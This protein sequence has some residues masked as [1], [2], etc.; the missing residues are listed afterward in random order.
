MLIKEPAFCF[1]HLKFSLQMFK[2]KPLPVELKSRT[3]GKQQHVKACVRG[4]L[5]L[6]RKLQALE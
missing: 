2:V 3:L 6:L 1:S 5:E 4:I